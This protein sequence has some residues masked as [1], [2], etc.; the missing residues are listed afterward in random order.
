MK[1]GTVAFDAADVAANRDAA[2]LGYVLFFMPLLSCGNSRLGRF[3]ANQ[4]L[5]LSLCYLAARVILRSFRWLFLFGFLYDFAV[6][7]VGLAALALGIYMAVQL[8]KYGRVTQL[9]YVG[10]YTLIR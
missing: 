6:T 4:G 7:L 10:K 9:P 5:L 8:R 2:S 3:C 1:N